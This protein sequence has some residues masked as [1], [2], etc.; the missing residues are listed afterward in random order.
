MVGE[1]GV[2]ADLGQPGRATEDADREFRAP[3]EMDDLEGRALHKSGRPS[4]LNLMRPERHLQFQRAARLNAKHPPHRAVGRGERAMEVMRYPA[5]TDCR[6]GDRVPGTDVELWAVEEVHLV[7]DQIGVIVVVPETGGILLRSGES[8]LY[9]NF[10]FGPVFLAC[11][12]QA[13]GLRPGGRIQF[14]PPFINRQHARLGKRLSEQ[15]RQ[16]RRTSCHGCWE[17]R[18][19]GLGTVLAK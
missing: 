1:L 15:G 10:R 18:G 7:I 13:E 2:E 19:H 6:L 11:A 4:R 3:T 16:E 9:T 5:G 12:P 8:A 14:R 17:H